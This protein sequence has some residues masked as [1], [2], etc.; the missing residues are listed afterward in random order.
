MKCYTCYMRPDT[1]I[2]C[3]QG[4]SLYRAA[5]NPDVYVL[6]LGRSGFLSN[7]NT[8]AL[9]DSGKEPDLHD[10]KGTKLVYDVFPVETGLDGGVHCFKLAKPVRDDKGVA[11]VRFCFGGQ[12]PERC[13]AD[14]WPE[15]GS[16]APVGIAMCAMNRRPW[17]TFAVDGAW[18][19]N[20]GDVFL[21]ES[22]RVREKLMLMES[23]ME[24]I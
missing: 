10:S 19:V 2:M 15:T 14:V 4:V 3:V 24:I 18:V 9:C 5:R 21:V 17:P 8:I 12:V 6:R 13:R 16:P 23:G 7:E 11:F 20:L 22:E 1:R